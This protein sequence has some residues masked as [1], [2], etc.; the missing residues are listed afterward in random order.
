LRDPRPHGESPLNVLIEPA[1]IVLALAIITA[2]IVGR[3]LRARAPLA[4][5]L[6]AATVGAGLGA[7]AGERLPID[8]LPI[9]GVAWPAPLVGALIAER[10]A[11]RISSG[12][13]RGR[14]P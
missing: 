3:L 2:T 11:A 5:A 4:A 8:L 10:F 14:R 7:L 1:P 12:W 6:A 9:G 13:E